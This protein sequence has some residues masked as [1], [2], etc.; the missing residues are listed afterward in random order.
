MLNR[1]KGTNMGSVLNVT[2]KTITP[3]DNRGLNK[4][5]VIREVKSRCA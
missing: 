5:E 4:G 3:Q 1:Y 2:G